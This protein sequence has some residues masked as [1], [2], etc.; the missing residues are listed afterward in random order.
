MNIPVY[1]FQG[2]VFSKTSLEMHMIMMSWIP[3]SL[4]WDYW[5][6]RNESC[7]DC[8]ERE[9]EE[10]LGAADGWFQTGELQY[11]GPRQGRAEEISAGRYRCNGGCWGVGD[12]NSC[13]YSHIYNVSRVLLKFQ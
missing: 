13:M 6:P 3:L 10:V 12:V 11:C 5:P 7:P 2:T 9:T 1:I 8:R 4:G